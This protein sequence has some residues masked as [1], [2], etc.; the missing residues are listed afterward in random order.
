MPPQDGVNHLSGGSK[1]TVPAA[2]GLSIVPCF[3][4]PYDLPPDGVPGT[5]SF[6]NVLP[7]LP[8]DGQASIVG[9]ASFE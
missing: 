9:G 6:P 3:E 8:R 5:H 4:G 7:P 1:P 2:L